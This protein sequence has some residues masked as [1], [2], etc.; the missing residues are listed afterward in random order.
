[1]RKERS[2]NSQ[3]IHGQKSQSCVWDGVIYDVTKVELET[4]KKPRKMLKYR[5]RRECGIDGGIE[6]KEEAIKPIF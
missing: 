5:E 2:R 1:M 6:A 4:E 3:Q